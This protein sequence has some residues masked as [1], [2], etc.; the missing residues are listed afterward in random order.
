M[1]GKVRG[2]REPEENLSLKDLADERKFNEFVSKSYKF[3]CALAYQILGDWDDAY[4]AVQNALLGLWQ[5][6]MERLRQPNANALSLAYQLVNSRALDILRRREKS[7]YRSSE[8]PS[9]SSDGDGYNFE[10]E[11]AFQ[12]PSEADIERIVIAIE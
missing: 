10:S 9:L 5:T 8:N 7:V 12:F 6:I 4:D 11:E 3:L 1:M 2:R